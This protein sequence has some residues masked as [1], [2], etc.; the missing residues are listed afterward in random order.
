MEEEAF[1]A[2]KYDNE[3]HL[4]FLTSYKQRA[5]KHASHADEYSTAHTHTKCGRKAKWKIIFLVSSHGSH[6]TTHT[7]SVIGSA[8][9]LKISLLCVVTSCE[10][11]ASSG[12]DTCENPFEDE[13]NV[14]APLESNKCFFE[15][16]NLH[17]K[18]P[19]ESM[20]WVADV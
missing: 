6:C 19:S 1:H 16:K 10:W 11:K 17:K 12:S 3:C 20:Q 9:V 13:N 14:K 7:E 8:I 4:K 18:F 15:G 5:S 2:T